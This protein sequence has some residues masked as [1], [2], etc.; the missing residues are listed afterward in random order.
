MIDYGKPEK[1][2]EIFE[3]ELAGFTNSETCKVEKSQGDDFE[4]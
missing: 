3:A 4:T 2:T 1:K